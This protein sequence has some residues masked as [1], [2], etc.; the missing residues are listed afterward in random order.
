MK[1]RHYSACIGKKK[2]SWKL[3][4]LW[5]SFRHTAF[6]KR[7]DLWH[8]LK[9]RGD[10]GFD[11]SPDFLPRRP[12]LSDFTRWWGHSDKRSPQ[13]K[14]VMVHMCQMNH[15]AQTGPRWISF[16]IIQTQCFCLF[17]WGGGADEE[18]WTCPCHQWEKF[19]RFRQERVSEDCVDA[20]KQAD[21][22][23]YSSWY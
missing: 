18:E 23:E 12:I 21:H 3:Y 20:A 9:V 22:S 16:H 8:N 14:L 1:R 13:M 15:A 2:R 11:I 10:L 17:Y 6:F 7:K 5:N 19:K 4:N